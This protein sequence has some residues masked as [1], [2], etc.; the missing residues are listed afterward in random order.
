M[1]LSH[2]KILPLVIYCRTPFR[3]EKSVQIS[4]NIISTFPEVATKQ[5]ICFLTVQDSSLGDL[6]SQSVNESVNQ[7]CFDFRIFRALLEGW[8][9][10][11]WPKR[12]QRQRHLEWLKVRIRK[13]KKAPKNLAF[14]NYVISIFMVSI[15]IIFIISNID[16]WVG[17]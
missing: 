8:A 15:F 1:F 2:F 17:S 9:D 5:H 13:L 6:V 4:T 16:L 3:H 14:L 12:R 11:T 10:I 7:E